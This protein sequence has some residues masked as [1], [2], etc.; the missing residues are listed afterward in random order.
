MK[1]YYKFL[2]VKI[3]SII[4]YSTIFLIFGFIFAFII[5]YFQFPLYNNP[6]DEKNNVVKRKTIFLTIEVVLTLLL[7]VVVFYFIRKLT[8]KI[9][10]PLEGLYGF[11]QKKLQELHGVVF[12]APVFFILQPRL[13]NKMIYLRDNVFETKY[14][15]NL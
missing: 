7:I 1:K 8:K 9:P 6:E 2:L 5:N 15:Y 12:F 14:F 3:S 10:F 11:K 4:Y 13:V